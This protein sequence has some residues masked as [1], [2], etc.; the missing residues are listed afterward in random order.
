[1][2]H[3][4]H[5]GAGSVVGA[6]AIVCDGSVVGSESV[7][8][9]GSCVTQRSRF[10]R[11]SVLSGFPAAVAGQLDA[12]PAVPAWAFTRDGLASIVRIR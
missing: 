7:V 10:P 5:V 1:M 2:I 4:C 3:G 6:G 9:A 8:H 11:R 12:P